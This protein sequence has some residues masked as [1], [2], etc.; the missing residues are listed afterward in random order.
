[1]SERNQRSEVSMKIS[2][3]GELEGWEGYWMSDEE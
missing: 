3:K 1:M 2:R